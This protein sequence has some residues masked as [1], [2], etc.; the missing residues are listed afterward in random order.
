MGEL[1]SDLLD[2]VRQGLCNVTT[3]AENTAALGASFYNSVGL[4]GVGQTSANAARTWSNMRSRACNLPPQEIPFEGGVPGG[5]CPGVQYQVTTSYQ[6]IIYLN[7]NVFN[8]VTTNNVSTGPGPISIE[9]FDTQPPNG[10][11][12]EQLRYSNGN[13]AGGQTIGG[14]G[15]NE[16]F[17]VIRLQL[18]IVRLDGLP[19]DCG[20]VPGDAVPYNP[21]DFT[22]TTPF[23]YTDADGVD[24][25][26][27]P[28][29]V[30]APVRIG[31][32]GDF[33]VPFEI[34]L[35]DGGPS[36]GDFNL[37]TGDINIGG[38]NSGGGGN[39]SPE[40]EVP[41]DEPLGEFDRII[42]V[43]VVSVVPNLSAARVN[44]IFSDDG[45][46]PLV[47]PRLAT[48]VFE[49]ETAVGDGL[50]EAFDVKTY[51]SIIYSPRDALSVQVFP[52]LG[53]NVTY[54]LIV[55]TSSVEGDCCR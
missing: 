8:D 1:N 2:Y 28:N 4:R 16:T 55:K 24:R 52:R 42:G 39:S 33:V 18:D 9:T 35:D 26:V 44:E 5:Q 53:V 27:N 47:I 6:A 40:R 3:L 46:P 48:V 13:F 32:G 30:F 45:S 19:D 51:N 43:R 7:G 38:G 23:T 29:L 21:S 17:E 34:T 41:P 36:F 10:I 12:G 54:T 22:L 37:T 11:V 20:E 15:A 31:P 49:M 25:T 50:S 14:G